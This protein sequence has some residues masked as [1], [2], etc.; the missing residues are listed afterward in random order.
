[1]RY[2]FESRNFKVRTE[3][4]LISSLYPIYFVLY[5]VMRFIFLIR[6]RNALWQ[7][8]TVNVYFKIGQIASNIYQ[9]DYG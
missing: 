7:D 5:C 8:I 1:M 2:F 6:A 4:I 3:N 9:E